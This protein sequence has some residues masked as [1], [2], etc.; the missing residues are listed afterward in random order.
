MHKQACVP[1]KHLEGSMKTDKTDWPPFI[2]GSRD[3]WGGHG[4]EEGRSG[5]EEGLLI[6]HPSRVFSQTISICYWVF[7]FCF[8]FP[9]SYLIR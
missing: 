7:R 4:R 2:W 3:G 5:E 8:V 6:L 9:D 1:R